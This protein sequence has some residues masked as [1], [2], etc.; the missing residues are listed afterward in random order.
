MIPSAMLY[1]MNWN[2]LRCALSYWPSSRTVGSS[3]SDLT[4]ESAQ[5][6]IQSR[7]ILP[8]RA[9]LST[10]HVYWFHPRV[11]VF[12]SLRNLFLDLGEVGKSYRN[13]K[14]KL[15]LDLGMI[16]KRRLTMSL[17]PFRVLSCLQAVYLAAFD[18]KTTMAY[19]RTGMFWW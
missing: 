6:W 19:W 15:T 11:V 4:D 13:L 18:S 8:E 3:L 14:R 12:Q 1:P 7:N 17:R 9:L 2:R 16:G 5:A 10:I